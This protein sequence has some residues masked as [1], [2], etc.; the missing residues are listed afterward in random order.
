LSDK[1]NTSIDFDLL[2][3]LGRVLILS[4]NQLKSL[5]ATIH[6]AESL[7]I[8][9]ASNNKIKTLPKTINKSKSIEVLDLSDNVIKSL[10]K[11][12]YELGAQVIL[13]GNRISELPDAN[14]KNHSCQSQYIVDIIRNVS[15]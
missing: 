15:N 5:P 14:V 6:K 3:V 9:D 1:S 12:I 4:G 8:V 13:K 7:A 10:K 2:I 11:N